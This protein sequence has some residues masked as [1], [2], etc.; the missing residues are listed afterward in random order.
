MAL[1][2]QAARRYAEAAAESALAHGE[3]QLDTLVQELSALA[4]ALAINHD[5]E[6]VL[7]NPAFG[8]EERSKVVESLMEH[9]KLSQLTRQFMRLVS[10]KGRITELTAIA[11]AVKQ[12]ADDRAGRTVAFVETATEL[13]P[14]SLEQLKRALERRTGKKLEMHVKIDPA[15][16]GGV[17]ARVGTFLLDGTIQTELARLRERL[18]ET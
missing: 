7:M 11:E 6:S 5:L 18:A 2:S 4:G 9:M 1:V 14:A 17:R 16:I 10:D 8:T 3:A 15:V 13:A 12:I